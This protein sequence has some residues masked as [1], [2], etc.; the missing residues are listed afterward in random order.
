MRG[1]MPGNYFSW[2]L[3]YPEEEGV[4]IVLRNAYG[5][6]EHL[7]QNL[8]AILFDRDPQM[9]SRN[10]KDTLA[11]AWLVPEAWAVSHRAPSVVVLLLL[12]ALTWQLARR[13]KSRAEWP[14]V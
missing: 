8:Q 10:A 4:I 6:T 7:E 2:I 9:P 3:R 5:S 11:R 14:G 1:D 12:L 13:R